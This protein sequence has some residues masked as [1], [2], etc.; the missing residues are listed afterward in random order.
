M[1]AH[2]KAEGLRTAGALALAAAEISATAAA[3]TAAAVTAVSAARKHAPE[4]QHVAHRLAG[5][6]PE[7]DRRPNTR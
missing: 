4:R 5:R 6:R 3:V 1:V 2:S 7:Y